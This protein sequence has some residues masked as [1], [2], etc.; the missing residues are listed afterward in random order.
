MCRFSISNKMDRQDID[1]YLKDFIYKELKE[2]DY[3]GERSL[4]QML[5]FCNKNKI[6]HLKK[7]IITMMKLNRIKD[8]KNRKI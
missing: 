5:V 8:L 6:D 1:T 2:H 3:Q 4:T 7:M